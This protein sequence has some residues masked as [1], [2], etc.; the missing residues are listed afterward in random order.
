MT[1]ANRLVLDSSVALAWYFR[2]EANPYADAI[3][4]LFPNLE[5]W[6]PSLWHLEVGSALLIGERRRRSTSTDAQQWLPKLASLNILTD[7]Q[8]A[9]RALDATLDLARVQGLTIYGASYL[10][11]ATRRGL[12]LATLDQK[13]RSAATAAGV[14]LFPIAP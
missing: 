12:P 14:P 8:T 5:A 3:A 2:D 10:E 13:L 11:L 6:V 1:V 9:E 7:L 4:R